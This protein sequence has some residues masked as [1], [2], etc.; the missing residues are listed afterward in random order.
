MLRETN[1]KRYKQALK[2]YKHRKVS[3]LNQLGFKVDK[4][5]FDKATTEIQVDNIARSIILG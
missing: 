3:I 5:V 1:T 4:E 2:V